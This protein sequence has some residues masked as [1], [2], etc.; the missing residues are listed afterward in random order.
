[1]SDV[2][3]TADERPGLSRAPKIPWIDIDGMVEPHCV[4]IFS[5]VH[6]ST[7]ARAR[8]RVGREHTFYIFPLWPFARRE[9][10][11]PAAATQRFRICAAAKKR[12]KN[13]NREPF[14]TEEPE[15]KQNKYP[16]RAFFPYCTTLVVFHSSANRSPALYPLTL[17][18]VQI[19]LV[20]AMK[21]K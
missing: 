4:G 15:G 5:I 19:A 1:M 6:Y 11:D 16:D 18:R 13:F 21:W 3:L 2:Q 12:P 17:T 7:W 10:G 20:L 14:R 9:G 8:S